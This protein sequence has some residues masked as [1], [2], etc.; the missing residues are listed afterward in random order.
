MDN[1]T[2]GSVVEP[3]VTGQPIRPTTSQNKPKLLYII[4]IIIEA[5]IIVGLIAF[6]LI[7]Y[8]SDQDNLSEED[9]A[10]EN[11]YID[12]S[13]AYILSDEEANV[14]MYTYVVAGDAA[15]NGQTMPRDFCTT[16]KEIYNNAETDDMPVDNLCV[17]NQIKLFSSDLTDEDSAYSG[18]LHLGIL[19]NNYTYNFYILS[20]FSTLEYVESLTDNI[21]TTTVTLN[22]GS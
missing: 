7:S 14:L 1:Y 20:G 10:T 8:L 15:F 5:I 22:V 3:R 2:S 11:G 16:L 13:P 21:P 17:D 4:I 18:M 19:L 9:F 12:D 6:L